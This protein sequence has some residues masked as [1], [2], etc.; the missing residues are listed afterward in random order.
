MSV[1]DLTGKLTSGTRTITVELHSLKKQPL[2]GLSFFT[3]IFLLVWKVSVVLWFWFS[4]R[5]WLGGVAV[6]G[7]RGWPTFLHTWWQSPINWPLHKDRLSLHYS[8]REVHL[9][10]CQPL[11]LQGSLPGI[12]FLNDPF[13]PSFLSCFSTSLPH[14]APGS[15]TVVSQPPAATACRGFLVLC[16]LFCV[17]RGNKRNFL[18]C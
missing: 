4:C 17:S 5:L 2:S 6:A 12:L 3:L 18:N 16:I 13:W 10:G 15:R 11:F 8:A 9:V 7:G 1:E 14:F